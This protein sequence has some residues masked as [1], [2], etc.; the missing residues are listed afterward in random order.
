MDPQL[1][2]R[3]PRQLLLLD[4]VGTLMTSATIGLLFATKVID[5]GLPTWV[6]LFMA[7]VAFG[8]AWFDAVG[9]L[10]ATNPRF[11]L[12]LMAI[13]NLAYCVFSTVICFLYFEQL[14]WIGEIYFA[15][16]VAVVVLIGLWE[17]FVFCSTDP[18]YQ[19]NATL[20]EKS[21]S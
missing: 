10:S 12:L 13:L 17:C 6:L 21:G 19:L 3:S 15:V 1:F 5:C 16:E 9:V 14:N 4:L 18:K 20:E 11:F 2:I 7:T 8:F